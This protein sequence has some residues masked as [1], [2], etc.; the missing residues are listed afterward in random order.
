[1]TRKKKLSGDGKR[2]HGADC[3]VCAK[4]KLYRQRQRLAEVTKAAHE[5]E[6]LTTPQKGK[7]G[8]G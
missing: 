4:P 8:D 3:G 2:A 6:R 1:M 7:V 5:P